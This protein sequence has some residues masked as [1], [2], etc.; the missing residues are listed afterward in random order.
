M[1]VGLLRDCKGETGVSSG[2]TGLEATFEGEGIGARKVTTALVGRSKPEDV[3]CW[4][5]SSGSERTER[6]SSEEGKV[7]CSAA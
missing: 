5:S 2:E 6:Q 7:E 4:K 3:K 1:V